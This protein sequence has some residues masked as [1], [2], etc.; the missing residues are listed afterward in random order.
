MVETS[1]QLGGLH[2]FY[3]L[4]LFF[5]TKGTKLLFKLMPH[6]P[7]LLNMLKRFQL[8][9]A[10]LVNM[11]LINKDQFFVDMAKK[12]CLNISVLAGQPLAFNKQ[13]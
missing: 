11:D 4:Q 5:G 12:M 6:Q 1:A 9:L 2:N 3:K 7:T 13:L 10:D 8:Y